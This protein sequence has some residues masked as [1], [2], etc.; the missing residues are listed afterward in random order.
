MINS[1]ESLQL[2]NGM[3]DAT[4]IGLET[5]A[6]SRFTGSAL[7]TVLKTVSYTLTLEDSTVRG[8]TTSAALTFTLPKAAAAFAS[9]VGQVYTLKKVAG[10]N[11][12]TLSGDTAELIDGSNTQAV[13]TVLRVQSN[14]VGWDI[15]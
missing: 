13:V 8:D 14:G 1:F 10:A 15:I 4:P 9:N 11:A 3:V 5:P 6:R 12:L 2:L 7:K